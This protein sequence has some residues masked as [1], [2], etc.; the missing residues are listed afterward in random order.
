LSTDEKPHDLA[1]RRVVD[2]GERHAEIHDPNP[3]LDEPGVDHNAR[4]DELG[5]GHDVGLEVRGGGRLP[6]SRG[7]LLVVEVERGAAAFSTDENPHNLAARRVVDSGERHAEIHDPNPRLDEPGAD[8]NARLDEPVVDHNARIDELGVDHDARLEE[9][10]G[11]RLP[12]PR[13]GLARP[14]KTSEL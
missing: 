9:R 2:S 10:G 7:G 5:V 12:D 1:A 13:G 6:D 4:L 8:H 11:G 14:A 3:R